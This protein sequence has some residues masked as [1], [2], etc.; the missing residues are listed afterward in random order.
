VK[1]G[2]V[3]AANIRACSGA[4]GVLNGGRGGANIPKADREQVYR[5]LQKH[6]KD[7]GKEAPELLSTSRVWTRV[8]NIETANWKEL[9]EDLSEDEVTALAV[10]LLDEEGNTPT[11]AN[12]ETAE[13]ANVE[14]NDNAESD[15]D[16]VFDADAARTELLAN[17]QRQLSLLT[18]MLE[19]R[20]SV[21][22]E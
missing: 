15:V 17:A 12:D 22:E 9:V 19:N 1:D 6:I 13:S 10:A 11:E 21:Q 7:A 20:T 5:H 8:R 4:I 3:G 18:A 16:E 14:D 2:K